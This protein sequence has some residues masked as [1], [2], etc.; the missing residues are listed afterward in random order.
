MPASQ[1]TPQCAPPSLNDMMVAGSVRSG[2]SESKE[3][4]TVP[5]FGWIDSLRRFLRMK[6]VTLIAGPA[7]KQ[8]I[9]AGG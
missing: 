9:C 7:E 3:N 8:D 4:R 1:M 2:R 5:D 6:P